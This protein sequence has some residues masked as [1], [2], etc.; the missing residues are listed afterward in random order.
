[1]AHH[2]HHSRGPI[3]APPWSLLRLS[4]GQRLAGAGVLSAV[5]W[6]LVFWAVRA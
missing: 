1:M 2:H 4:A 5:L 6:A 3:V